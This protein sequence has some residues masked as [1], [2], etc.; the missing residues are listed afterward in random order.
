MKIRETYQVAKYPT[1]LIVE[2]ED[3]RLRWATFFPACYLVEDD[4]PATTE[5][6]NVD[7]NCLVIPEDVARTICALAY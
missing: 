4:A 2:L 6:Y 5:P 7:G 3:G 1:K